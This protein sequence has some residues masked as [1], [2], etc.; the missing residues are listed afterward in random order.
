MTASTSFHS[1]DGNH[2]G[3]V[4]IYLIRHGETAWSLTGQHTGRTDIALS[5]HGET[6][7]RELASPLAHIQFSRVLVSPLLRA[8]QTCELAG[9][10]RGS[11]IESDLAEWD[12]GDYE[13]RLSADIWKER[14]GWNVWRDGCPGGERP[15]DVSIRANRVV[16][17]LSTMQGNI[18]LFS[19]GQFGAALA[20]RWIGLPVIKGQHFVLHPASLSILGYASTHPDLPII[21]LWNGTAATKKCT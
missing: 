10:Q 1:G 2:V 3:P 11:E 17:R 18:A 6:E 21:T 19:H 13:G 5:E 15:R 20:A 8:R 12:Y 14:Q 4:H 16:T 7:A 9:L